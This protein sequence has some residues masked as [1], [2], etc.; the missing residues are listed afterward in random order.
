MAACRKAVLSRPPL[1]PTFHASLFPPLGPQTYTL[2]SLL[3]NAHA[4]PC[5]AMRKT[6]PYP[7]VGSSP[8]REAR[9]GCAILRAPIAA[10]SDVQ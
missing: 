7:S 6:A 8:G 10:V 2:A 5:H 3:C 4:M 1:I 9:P